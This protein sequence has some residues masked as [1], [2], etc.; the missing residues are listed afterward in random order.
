MNQRNF[1]ST[2]SPNDEDEFSVKLSS[3]VLK[4]SSE[5]LWNM[6]KVDILARP[7][8]TTLENNWRVEDNKM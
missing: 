6:D 5:M 7:L 2:I 4:S 8:Q 1:L 3:A